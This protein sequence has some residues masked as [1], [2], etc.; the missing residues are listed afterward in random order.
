VEFKIAT[1]NKPTNTDIFLAETGCYLFTRDDGFYISGCDTQAEADA[2][3]AAHNPPAPVEPTVAEKL[4]SV[5]LT[6][7]D[8]RAALGLS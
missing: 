1:P 2:L 4:E 3:I 8:L 7:D 6:L 5:G